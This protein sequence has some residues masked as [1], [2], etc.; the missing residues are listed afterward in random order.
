MDRRRAEDH[1]HRLNRPTDAPL[2]N[3]A[4]IGLYTGMRLDE[5][6]ETRVEDIHADHIHIPGGKTSSAIRDVPLHAVI[7]PLVQRLKKTSTDEYLFPGLKPGGRD[8]KRSH[9]PSKR[10]GARI[11]EIGIKDPALVFHSLRNTFI[12]GL[13]QSGTPRDTAKL[14][15]G[16]KRQDLTYGTYS[17]GV[18]RKA[19]ADAVRKVSH[20]KVDALVRK[21]TTK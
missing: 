3:L 15:V 21:L 8:K 2:R 17:H 13:E 19:L 11:R 6:A 18:T 16:H 20:G 9:Y 10:F 12:Q 5:I 14:I 1:A 7:R 4:T